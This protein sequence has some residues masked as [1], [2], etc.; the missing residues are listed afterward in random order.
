M[1]RREHSTERVRQREEHPVYVSL[2]LLFQL[3][4]EDDKCEVPGFARQRGASGGAEAADM[5]ETDTPMSEMS[6]ISESGGDPHF[7]SL[8]GGAEAAD[9]SQ[10]D[11]PI[12]EISKISMRGGDPHFLSLSGGAEAAE[13]LL[14][15]CAPHTSAYVSIRQR[16]A[17]D[18]LL[19]M[20]APPDTAIYVPPLDLSVRGGADAAEKRGMRL[21]MR[22]IRVLSLRGGA[23]AAKP[24]CEGLTKPE[25]QG[26]TKPLV[27]SLRGGAD[28]ADADAD[29]AE[30]SDELTKP[31]SDELTKPGGPLSDNTL[32][33][34]HQGRA[35][36]VSIRQHTSAYVSIRQ[37]TSAYVS[38]RQHTSAHYLERQHSQPQ[39]SR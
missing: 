2:P 3:R 23:D 33:R 37:H 34:S 8:S 28:A 17:A 21:R 32:S 29:A 10:R 22:G 5:S 16:I 24:L 19:Y 18:V 4:D 26:L 7:L 12:S 30:K 11:T 31:L 35:A 27:L 36:Y 15:L 13:R 9:M 20:C 39:P 38:I 1:R 14:Y 6:K 25:Y